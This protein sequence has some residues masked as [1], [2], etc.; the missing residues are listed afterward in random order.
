ML[1]IYGYEAGNTNQSIRIG[2]V[3]S[4]K[5]WG[6][7][8]ASELIEALVSKLLEVGSVLSVVGGVAPSNVASVRVLTKNGFQFLENSNGTDFYIRKLSQSTSV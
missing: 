7:G 2:Y 1:L 3:I 4:E 5:Y 6:N 8:F